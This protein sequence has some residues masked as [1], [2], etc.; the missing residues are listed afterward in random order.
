MY[1]SELQPKPSIRNRKLRTRD[2]LQEPDV[3]TVSA[4]VAATEALTLMCITELTSSAGC[5]ALELVEES[6]NSQATSSVACF[7]LA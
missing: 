3:I 4:G 7:E 2:N 1:L 6:V 5:R